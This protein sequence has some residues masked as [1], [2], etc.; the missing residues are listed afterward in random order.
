MLRVICDVT[1]R[2]FGLLFCLLGLL[3]LHGLA[4]PDMVGQSYLL[5]P[6]ALFSFISNRTVVAAAAAMELAIGFYCLKDKP[7]IGKAGFMS[8]FVVCSLAYRY[9]LRLIN[10]TGPCGC[11]LGVNRFL[12][13]TI[14][15]QRILADYILGAAAAACVGVLLVAI[16]SGRRIRTPSQSVMAHS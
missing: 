7:L 9:S 6:N 14:K 13:M 1:M 15:T 5:L 4:F 8:W 11:L 16:L 3:K 10:Y 2:G 12:P